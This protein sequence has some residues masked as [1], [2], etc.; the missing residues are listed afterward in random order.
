MAM[1]YSIDCTR[2]IYE[3]HQNGWSMTTLAEENR[4]LTLMPILVTITITR[5]LTL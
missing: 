5:T 1:T 2:D 4:I 3:A